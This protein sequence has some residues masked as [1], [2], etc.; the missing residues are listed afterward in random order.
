MVQLPEQGGSII[1]GGLGEGQPEQGGSIIWAGLGAG[2]GGTA[3]RTRWE[4]N[5]GGGAGGGPA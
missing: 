3:A 5:R 2:P 4:H 1:G